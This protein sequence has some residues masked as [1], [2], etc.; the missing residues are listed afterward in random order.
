MR[1]SRVDLSWVNDAG[2]G[3]GDADAD[4]DADVDADA[5]TA[6]METLCPSWQA[7]DS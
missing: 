3:D 6:I 5:A 4:A 1:P 7:P 2:D